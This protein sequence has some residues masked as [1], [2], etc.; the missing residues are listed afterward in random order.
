VTPRPATTPQTTAAAPGT[1]EPA[2]RVP[3]P[4]EQVQV[5]P[6][7]DET[8]SVTGERTGPGTVTAVHGSGPHATVIV[9]L[10]GGHSVP[11]RA[12]E[13]V[14]VRSKD[15]RRAELDK[16]TKAR[17]IAMYRGGVRTPEGRLAR[18]GASAHPIGT[19]SKA[20]VTASIMTAEFP[21]E[22]TP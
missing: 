2:D 9:A 8:L 6:G 13:L 11:Y 5:R 16:L 1:G 12:A 22:V 18:Y 21:P 17:L 15:S 10:D 14:I 3:V 19:W 7:C 20:D 4:G